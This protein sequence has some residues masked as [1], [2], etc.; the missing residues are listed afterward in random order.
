[1]VFVILT[2]VMIFLYIIHQAVFLVEVNCV[3]CAVR[4]KF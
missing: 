3:L 1:M 4:A 2:E